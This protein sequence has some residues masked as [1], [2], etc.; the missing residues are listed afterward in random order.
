M[1]E[2]LTSEGLISLFTLTILEI[3]LGIDNV[4]FISIVSSKLPVE[5]QAKARNIGIMMALFAR[6]ALLFGI[7]WIIGL[8][9]PIVSL[10]FL[11]YLGMTD[12][13][14]S[15]RDLILLAGGLFLIAKSTSE[16]HGKLEGEEEGHA[17]SVKQR[18]LMMAIFQILLIDVVF[19]FDSILTAVGLV[20]NVLIMIVAVV[21]S[22]GV[23]LVFAGAIARSWITTPPSRCLPC[24]FWCS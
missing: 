24:R 22:L 2:M 8:Q 9:E 10:P 16:I 13:D 1:Q 11:S 18:G 5:I 20:K 15:G 17:P 3:I 7:T 6:I 19:S 23:M 12:T 14:L 4:I 21:I